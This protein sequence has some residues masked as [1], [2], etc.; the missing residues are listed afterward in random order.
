MMEPT[1]ENLRALYI[2]L[3][4]EREEI[5]ET[6]AARML[7]LYRVEYR[8]WANIQYCY[9]SQVVAEARESE[10]KETAI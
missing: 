10:R 9:A 4:V 3:A 7:G 5:G 6:A 1:K 2:L 8:E